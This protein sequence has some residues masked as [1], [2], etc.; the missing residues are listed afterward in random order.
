MSGSIPAYATTSGPLLLGYLFNWGLLGVLS[1]QVYLYYLAFPSDRR[2]TKLL[3]AGIYVLELIQTI[4]M[5]HDAFGT[6]ATHFGDAAFLDNIQLLPLSIPIISGPVS[7]AVQMHYGYLLYKLSGSRLLGSVVAFFAVIQCSAALVQGVQAFVLN[8]LSELATKAFVSETVWL[9]GSLM[10]DILIACG[11]TYVL[12]KKD[13]RLPVTHAIITKLVR[14]VVETGCLTAVTAVIQLVL[15]VAFPKKLYFAC[16]GFAL[17]KFY[18]NSLLA[19]LNSRIRIEGV[20]TDPA[21]QMMGGSS[22]AFYGKPPTSERGA[23]SPCASALKIDHNAGSYVVDVHVR[24]HTEMW[25]VRDEEISKA[26]DDV[27]T[28]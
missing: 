23:A 7:C 19:I 3:V 16:V 22:L 1:V 20:H 13:T 28:P 4:L 15:L 6:Y 12:W 9:S 17:S 2:L 10:C 8:N 18:S 27:G 14:I 21:V 5:T 25:D 26:V 11:M 24:H